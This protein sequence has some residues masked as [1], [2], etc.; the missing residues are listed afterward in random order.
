MKHTPLLIITVLILLALPTGQALALSDHAAKDHHMLLAKKQG[1]PWRSLSSDE[2]EFLKKHRRN[3]PAYSPDKQ[4]KLHRSLQRYIELP[5]E[6]HRTLKQKRQH[7]KELSPE[8]R[9]QLR[10]EYRKRKY[11]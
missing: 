9:R 7:Y 2:R 6:Q 3:W 11:E 8:E 1:I 4:E 10:K 5:P